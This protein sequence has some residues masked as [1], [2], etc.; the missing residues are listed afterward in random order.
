VLSLG[1]A[2]KRALWRSLGTAP[3]I[4]EA[5][6]SIDLDGLIRSADAQLERV[7]LL[8]LQAAAEV[9]VA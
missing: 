8:R 2:G 5:L 3:S 9:F 7:E 1:I 4:N 6:D